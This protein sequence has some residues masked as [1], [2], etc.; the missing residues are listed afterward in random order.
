M[1]L[2]SGATISDASFDAGLLDGFITGHKRV[3]PLGAR[4]AG[5]ETVPVHGADTLVELTLEGGLHVIT[6]PSRLAEEFPHL[7]SRDAAGDESV[8]IPAVLAPTASRGLADG[9]KVDF[10]DIVD[11]GLDKLKDFLKGQGVEVAADIAADLVTRHIAACIDKKILGIE[12]GLYRLDGAQDPALVVPGKGELD[13][14]KPILLFLHG[15]F[16]STKWSYDKLW[17]PANK[18]IWADLRDAYGGRIVGLEHGTLSTSPIDNAVDLLKAL[19]DNPRLHVVAFSRGGM[20]GELLC[21]QAQDGAFFDAVD[22]EL[23]TKGDCEEQIDQ[24]RRLGALLAE[25]KP[26]VERFVRVGTPAAGTNLTSGKLD[27]WLSAV[28]SLVDLTGLG[29]S[30]VFQGVKAFTLAVLRNRSDA[31]QIPG[32]QAM[33]PGSAM[34]AILN[35]PDRETTADLSVIAGDIEGSGILHRFGVWLAD[36]YFGGQHDLVVDTLSMYGGLARTDN[37]ARSRFL[38]GPEVNHLKYFANPDSARLVRDGLLR[39]EGAN[40]GFEPFAVP[41]ELVMA[42]HRGVGARTKLFVLPG[43]TGSNLKKHGD[44]IWLELPELFRGQIKELDV[45]DPSSSKVEPDGAIENYYNELASRL[46]KSYEVEVFAYDWRLSLRDAAGKL[47]LRLKEALATPNRPVR[48]LAHSMGGLVAR[49][50][51]QMEPTIFQEFR[52]RQGC[53]LV[54]LGTP[55][56]GSYSIPRMLVAEEATTKSLAALDMKHDEGQILGFIAAMPGVLELMPIDGGLDMFDEATWQAIEAAKGGQGWTKPAPPALVAAA[57]TWADL[58]KAPVDPDCM[59]YVAGQADSTPSDLE[60]VG[61][62]RLRFVATGR[63]DGRV[64]WE[65]GILPGVTTY[66]AKADHGSLPATRGLFDAY[67]EILASGHTSRLPTTPPALARGAATDFELPADPLA[68]YPS[69]RSLEGLF[70]GAGAR[71]AAKPRP[72]LSVGLAHGDLAFAEGP[73]LVGHYRG[74]EIVGAE[75][76]LDKAL[77]R[78]LSARRGLGLYPGDPGECEVI[79]DD[80]AHPP[81]VVVVGLGLVG[82]LAPGTLRKALE[83]GLRRALLTLAERETKK[84][85]CL[86]ALLVGSG[87]GGVTLAQSIEMLLEALVRQPDELRES[88][89]LERVQIVEL[90][91]DRAIQAGRILQRMVES[92]R[93]SEMLDVDWQLRSIEGARRRMVFEEDDGWHRRLLVEAE[94][95]GELKF[96]T[97]TDKARLEVTPV[98]GTRELAENYIADAI[99]DAKSYGGKAG[100]TLYELLVPRRLKLSSKEDRQIVLMLNEHAARYPWELMDDSDDGEEPLAIRSGAIRQLTEHQ[101]REDVVPSTSVRALIVGDPELSRD[102]KRHFSQLAGA[103][104]EATSVADLLEGGWDVER[105]IGDTPTRSLTAIMTEQSKILHIAS[106]GVFETLIDNRHQTGAVLG[107]GLYLTTGAVDQMRHTPDLVFLNCCHLADMSPPRRRHDRLAANLARQFIRNGAK[108]VIAAGWAVD[109][110][111]ARH[112]AEYFYGAL[113]AGETFAEAVKQ[114]RR[115]IFHQY[116]GSNTWGAYQAYGDPGFVLRGE[117]RSA[118]AGRFRPELQT[119]S[120]AIIELEQISQSVQVA[121]QRDIAQENAR[122]DALRKRIGTRWKNDAELLAAIGKTAGELQRYEEAIDAYQQACKLEKATLPVRAVEQL[123]NLRVRHAAASRDANAVGTIK[124]AIEDLERLSELVGKET[125]ERLSLIGSAHKRLFMITQTANQLSCLR[126]MT[127]LYQRAAEVEKGNR[128]YPLLNMLLGQTLLAL[129]APSEQDAVASADFAERR[130]ALRRGLAVAD[131][132]RPDFW[133][134]SMLADIELIGMLHDPVQQ[135]EPVI[136]AYNKAWRR[137][138][139]P[140]KLASV[141]EH[142]DFVIEAL[143]R[144]ASELAETRKRALE[145]VGKIRQEVEKLGKGD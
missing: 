15:T 121:S 125:S 43:I 54:M 12:P 78:R 90:F 39:E 20:I 130:S 21:R 117:R 132:E 63:G 22:E 32:L 71:P 122:F 115:Q 26:Q 50:V 143:A 44:R 102:D 38:Q 73:L 109:D 98:S 101:F 34:T 144:G 141:L 118:A 2:R 25:K 30:P 94:K 81:G 103:R 137:G 36:Q 112:F 99:E 134:F 35:R 72:R 140:L 31:E 104:A 126:D 1:Q 83:T 85:A 64:P 55:N 17:S 119:A 80:D 136:D 82:Q 87:E 28:L 135:P 120:E 3:K 67:E 11:L 142:L 59:V 145:K 77:G 18:A 29:A 52:S 75:W 69:Q 65:T 56:R 48:I 13:G 106:H 57:A 124:T 93:L 79:L 46:S 70:L 62:S 86:S 76:A 105:V 51:F 58:K 128:A 131:G 8:R 5:V 139:S 16:S 4:D 123:A 42:E 113:L 138:G 91:E 53:R 14:D 110:D 92:G 49:L 89:G 88:A 127:K 116:P 33:L 133:N 97:V 108:V 7:A 60:I 100:R 96:T 47:A 95:E 6:T 129:R 40:A 27:R 84:P 10:A 68:V 24:L 114:A 37:K 61:G 66:Y 23:L 45:G 41:P 74:D 111:P 107:G 19:P 9:L